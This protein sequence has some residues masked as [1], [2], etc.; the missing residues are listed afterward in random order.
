[1]VTTGDLKQN[2][3]VLG[4]VGTTVNDQTTVQGKGGCGGSTTTSVT[5]DVNTTYQK[6]ADELLKLAMAKGGDAVVYATFDYRIAIRGTGN[7]A[8]QVKELFC[9]GTAVKLRS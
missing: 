8:K 4:I 5:V 2:Y 7:L 9:Y 6:G 1:M 3:D